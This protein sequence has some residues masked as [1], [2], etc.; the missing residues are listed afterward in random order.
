MGFQENEAA[1]AASHSLLSF[2]PSVYVKYPEPR[3]QGPQ[4]DA[5]WPSF[6]PP[7]PAPLDRKGC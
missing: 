4:F 5:E 2:H 1:S 3:S 6:E 7:E